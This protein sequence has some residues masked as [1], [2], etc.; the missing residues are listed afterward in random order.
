MGAALSRLPDPPPLRP[1]SR[2]PWCDACACYELRWNPHNG[3]VTRHDLDADDPW[4]AATAADVFGAPNAEAAGGPVVAWSGGWRIDV[5][6]RARLYVEPA[7]RRV[8][9]WEPRS[10]PTTALPERVHPAVVRLLVALVEGAAAAGRRGPC[11]VCLEAD[12]VRLSLPLCGHPVCEACALRLLA[13]SPRRPP[14]VVCPLCRAVHPAAGLLPLTRWRDVVDP[15]ARQRDRALVEAHVAARLAAADAAR[16][17]P[18]PPANDDGALD[19]LVGLRDELERAVAWLPLFG[20]DVGAL[21]KRVAAAR[22]GLQTAVDGVRAAAAARARAPVPS[23]GGPPRNPLP[24]PSRQRTEARRR[25]NARR[26]RAEAEAAE[27]A[28]CDTEFQRLYA[29][30]RSW[31][32]TPLGLGGDAERRPLLRALALLDER[33]IRL[34]PADRPAGYPERLHAMAGYWLTGLSGNGLR[35]WLVRDAP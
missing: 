15:G 17:R 4:R 13:E 19:E 8:C 9:L 20:D 18:P 34:G 30:Y 29:L 5:G 21:V 6:D 23:A 7:S 11:P 27:A 12:A 35:S 32:E 16:R 31:C 1:P 3:V 22:D 10:A 24:L 2:P 25:A 28:A 26:A 14:A 33:I